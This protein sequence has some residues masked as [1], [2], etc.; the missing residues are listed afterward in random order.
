MKMIR[1]NIWLRRDHQGKLK[2]ISE[3]TGESVSG[4]IRMAIEEYLK[5]KH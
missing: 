1:T 3:R 2:A 4:L 5:K